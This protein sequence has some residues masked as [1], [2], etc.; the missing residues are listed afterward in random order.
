[1]ANTTKTWKKRAQALVAGRIL[2]VYVL[3]LEAGSSVEIESFVSS[4]LEEN[5]EDYDQVFHAGVLNMVLYMM[6]IRSD[7]K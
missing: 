2:K 7:C 5:M 3:L 6:R 1:M 4:W